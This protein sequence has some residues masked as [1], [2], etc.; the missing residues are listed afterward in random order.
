MAGHG[1]LGKSLAPSSVSQALKLHIPT[2]C[3]SDCT[4]AL[5]P[6]P[7]E[8]PWDS[9]SRGTRLFHDHSLLNSRNQ[10]PDPH[11]QIVIYN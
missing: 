6:Y 3:L 10:F 2:H 8:V 4:L 1:P 7:F 9:S 11:S 5:Q